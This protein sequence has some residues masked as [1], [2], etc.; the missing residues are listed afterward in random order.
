MKRPNIDFLESVCACPN[1]GDSLKFRSANSILCAQCSS[2]FSTYQNALVL[3][4]K[5]NSLFRTS[6]YADTAIASDTQPCKKTATVKQSVTRTLKKHMPSKSI[7]LS[8]ERLFESLAKRIG[9]AELS[10]LVVGC[11][12]QT[13]QLEKYFGESNVTFVFCDIDKAADVD[14]FCDAHHLPFQAD[15][16]DGL[17]TTAVLEHVLYPEQVVAEI[18]RV[19]KVGAF[20]YS[21]VPFLQSVHEGA[22]DFTRYTM[23]GHRRLLEHFDEIE[24]GMVAGPAT[25]LVWSLCSFSKTLFK[26][27]FL[28]QAFSIFTQ[29]SL[30][31]IKY[32]DL[33]VQKNPAALDFA[34]CTYF[35]GEKI[36]SKV[37][38]ETIVE[39]YGDSSFTHV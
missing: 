32:F 39:K 25:A 19:L 16:F 9:E 36:A 33:L 17:I 1:C 2:E 23:S 31:W 12:N 37:S 22:Y 13:Q 7:N 28:S 4:S 38:P 11:G 5:E 20:I 14:I 29:Y 15:T 8:R 3:F 34:S 10:L 6:D 21:E 24:A 27:S 18:A 26:A 30:F 35:F